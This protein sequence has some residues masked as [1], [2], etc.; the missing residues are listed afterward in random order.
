MGIK[1]ILPILSW[2]PDYN[3]KHL[4]GDVSAGITVGIMLIPQG[5]AYAMLAGLPPIYGLY[6]ALVPQII[7]AFFGTSRQLG[8]G[9][10]AMDSL[11]VAVAVSQFAQA[12]SDHYITMA[13]LLAFMVG[14]IQ[15]MMGVMKLGFLVNLLSHPVISG[16]TSAAALIIGFSQLKYLLGVDLPRSQYFHEILWNAFQHISETNMTTLL[17]GM[18]GIFIIIGMKQRKSVIPAPMV[19]VVLGIIVVWFFRLD[20]VGVS[21]VREVPAGLPGFQ[22]PD[23]NTLSIS[24]LFGSAM[25]IALVAFME[26]IAVAKAIHAR[27]N[28]YKIDPDQELIALGMANFVG[29]FFSSFPGTGGFSRSAVNDQAGAKTNL[30]AMISAAFVFTTL[31]FLT[32][33]FFYLPKAILASVIMVA[34]FN[35]ISVKDAID[36]WK[37]K[38][39]RDLLILLITFF[40]TLSSGIQAGIFSGVI[41]SI[42]LMLYDTMYPEV[43][44]NSPGVKLPPNVL[45]IRFEERLYFGNSN[46]FIEKSEILANEFLSKIKDKS[47]K[48]KFIILD[49]LSIHHTDSTGKKALNHLID[50]FKSKNLKILIISTS[51]KNGNSIF[52]CMED[53]LFYINRK[54]NENISVL[55]D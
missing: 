51:V 16:F 13:V 31:L 38:H 23:L 55:C 34:V 18:S 36:L 11:L 5:M 28:D 53:A 21:I 29:S 40:A 47:F 12:G 35:L 32:P 43:I 14:M 9:P 27:H 19:V 33:L 8:V 44:I 1:K 25:T 4:K 50:Y 48:D 3:I 49:V 42:C 10:V 26:A 39:R 22:V 6:A 46:F 54:A 30:A 2:L 41:V 45:F 20:S 37:N 7:Y 52:Q 17:I 15:L 24:Q